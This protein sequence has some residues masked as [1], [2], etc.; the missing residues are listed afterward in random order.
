MNKVRHFW[1]W[2][3]AWHLNWNNL[4][5]CKQ[6]NAGTRDILCL[7]PC[8]ISML[9]SAKARSSPAQLVRQ[10]KPS[11]RSTHTGASS[12]LQLISSRS[13]GSESP[14]TPSSVLLKCKS[15]YFLSSNAQIPLRDFQKLIWMPVSQHWCSGQWMFYVVGTCYHSV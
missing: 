14:C 4:R 6:L 7:A 8:T 9:F 3:F 13:R 1:P 5:K 2:E 11:H 15:K 10:E 12:G